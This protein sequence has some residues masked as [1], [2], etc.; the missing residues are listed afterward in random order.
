MPNIFQTG[1]PTKFKLGNR[2]NTKTRISDKCRDLQGQRWRS[3]G[4]VW[5]V[6]ADKS[7]MKRPRNTNIG[8]K[9]THPTGNNAYM[10]Q[11]QRSKVKGQGYMINNTTQ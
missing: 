1:R 5:Q 8:R 2:R 7:R 4:H 6:L 9:V 11:G 10:F 3:Q